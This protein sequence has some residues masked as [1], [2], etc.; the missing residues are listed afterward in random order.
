[1]MFGNQKMLPY[2]SLGHPVIYVL[3]YDAFEKPVYIQQIILSLT[4]INA[5][6]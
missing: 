1:M 3:R 4:I 5:I 6:D 2:F